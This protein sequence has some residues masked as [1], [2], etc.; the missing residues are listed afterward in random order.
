MNRNS[1]VHIIFTA[2]THTHVHPRLTC[3]HTHHD[4]SVLPGV[5]SAPRHDTTDNSDGDTTDNSDGSDGSE[6]GGVIELYSSTPLCTPTPLTSLTRR[7]SR[8][9]P[10]AAAPPSASPTRC[11]TTQLHGVSR[12]RESIS[13]PAPRTFRRF[14][15]AVCRVPC[16]VC[17]VPC[18]ASYGS[19]RSAPRP[20]HTAIWTQRPR[21]PPKTGAGSVIYISRRLP[22]GL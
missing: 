19:A 2:Y 18:R 4:I 3:M 17:R 20:S 8:S 6:R 12:A 13:R 21:L 14:R 16:P 10:A 7:G 5:V 1:F 9:R 11:L 22:S 15:R